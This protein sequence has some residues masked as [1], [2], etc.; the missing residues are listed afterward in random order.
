MT[1]LPQCFFDPAFADTLRREVGS[2]D[3]VDTLVAIP[4]NQFTVIAA[5]LALRPKRVLL[6][7]T[8]ADLSPQEA[9][10]PVEPRVLAGAA[11]VREFCTASG[12][13]FPWRAPTI[14]D[15]PGDLSGLRPASI[16]PT[17][18]ESIP[19]QRTISAAFLA[20]GGH[21]LHTA[22]LSRH[23]ESVGARVYVALSSYS[24]GRPVTESTR[25]HLLDTPAL[26]RAQRGLRRCRLALLD[27]AWGAAEAALE[28]IDVRDHPAVAPTVLWSRACRLRDAMRFEEAVS[29]S[30]AVLADIDRA[31]DRAR[32][33]PAL[34]ALREAASRQQENCR[35]LADAA[36]A[37][38]GRVMLIELL[39]RG[40]QEFAAGRTSHAALLYYRLAEACLSSRL[41]LYGVD[42]SVGLGQDV[43][44][45][46]PADS[47]LPPD[48]AT[49]H[50]RFRT[51]AGYLGLAQAAPTH[52]LGL[53][54]QVAAVRALGDAT[55]RAAEGGSAPI[56]DRFKRLLGLAH[57]RN[58]SIF[59]H[60][61]RPVGG[62]GLRAL[63]EMV[64]GIAQDQPP[65]QPGRLL[66]LLPKAPTGLLELIA[67]DGRAW[68][69]LRM[70]LRKLDGPHISEGGAEL[71]Q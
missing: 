21:S 61:F 55:V 18:A 35:A 48:G 51:V 5:V 62:E 32:A 52:A 56:E 39:L 31:P 3:P 22:L 1:D 44:T 64:T 57:E 16:L 45:R 43:P 11:A 71:F 53:M 49:L 7:H 13:P 10:P 70:Q 14:Q 67:P 59:A 20:T 24:N 65:A 36:L 4:S 15:V 2:S 9:E 19:E 41:R 25:V 27:H 37:G 6:L 68:G 8:S 40:E 46:C 69:A 12:W 26:V 30:E 28:G 34:R 38:E 42:P 23:A 29:A 33:N 58:S 63:R 50:E 60:G 17:L 66:P 54:A 47:E